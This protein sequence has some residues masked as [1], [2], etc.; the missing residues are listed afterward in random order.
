MH[1]D[2]D[3]GRDPADEEDVQ[4]GE[5]RLPPLGPQVLA[6]VPHLAVEAGEADR[7]GPGQRRRRRLSVVRDG[8]GGGCDGGR[9]CVTAGA[10]LVRHLAPL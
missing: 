7:G 6:K 4:E 2:H 3:E 1:D 8:G 9:G 5:E 10:Q